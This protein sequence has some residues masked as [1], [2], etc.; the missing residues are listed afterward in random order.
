[1]P[2]FNFWHFVASPTDGEEGNRA[3]RTPTRALAQRG[4]T[5]VLSACGLVLGGVL[6][7]GARCRPRPLRLR[8]PFDIVRALPFG[9]EMCAIARARRGERESRNL[10]R[11]ANRLDELGYLLVGQVPA[12]VG[13]G[14]DADQPPVF[15]NG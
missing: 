10:R 4:A 12:D 6:L 7:L 8:S 1:M 11:R 15:Q 2:T 13:F 5:A 9:D 14:D 3:A